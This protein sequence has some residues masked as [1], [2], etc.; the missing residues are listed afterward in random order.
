[1][2][3][4]KR[5]PAVEKRLLEVIKSGLPLKFV[6]AAAGISYDTLAGWRNKDPKFAEAV[7]I[8]RLASVEAQWQAIQKA[9]EDT[10]KGRGDWKA[11]AWCLERS[12]P[13]SFAKPDANGRV[14]RSQGANSGSGEWFVRFGSRGC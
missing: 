10:D 14:P 11:L 8:A 4:T 12:H 13:E 2:R 3:P 5:T 1:M 6:T 7:E 9:A